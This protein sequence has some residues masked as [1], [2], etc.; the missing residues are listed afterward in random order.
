MVQ[1]HEESKPRDPLCQQTTRRNRF[2]RPDIS[3]QAIA[4]DKGRYSFQ[5]SGPTDQETGEQGTT[6]I[7]WYRLECL[8]AQRPTYPPTLAEDRKLGSHTGTQEMTFTES[9]IGEGRS[10]D[11]ERHVQ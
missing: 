5:V 11:Q 8:P 7:G 2:P 9:R 1:N 4:T 6:K 3:V 10:E